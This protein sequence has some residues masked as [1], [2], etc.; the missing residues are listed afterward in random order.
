MN[1]KNKTTAETNAGAYNDMPH[2][3]RAIHE[4][5][6]QPKTKTITFTLLNNASQFNRVKKN[7]NYEKFKK[8]EQN[9]VYLHRC[10]K[11]KN[12][13]KSTQN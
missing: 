3:V 5:P 13:E 8:S 10:F 1:T 12:Y 4:L 6:L 7:K 2:S 9:V 11:I